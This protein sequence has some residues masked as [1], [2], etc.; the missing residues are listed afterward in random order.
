MLG[1][2]SNEF[3]KRSVTPNCNLM[4]Q[5]DCLL[6]FSQ[7]ARKVLVEVNSNRRMYESVI[8]FLGRN[9]V[10][11]R[12]PFLAEPYYVL[13]EMP[14]FY[15]ILKTLESMKAAGIFYDFIQKVE[16]DYERYWI[17]NVSLGMVTP[18]A[19]ALECSE[20]SAC[21]DLSDSVIAEDFVMF[22]YCAAICLVC[23]G[24]ELLF[25][26]GCPKLG[27]ML[28]HFRI[29]LSLKSAKVNVEIQTAVMALE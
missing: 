19:A 14:K 25:V 6:E 1:I 21:V 15:F 4:H 7:K 9:V 8:K 13:V 10:E 3:F 5:L 28:R 11:G 23:V 29:R 18:G 22:L 2:S 20:S 16:A 24:V 27:T 17:R 26:S 12:E